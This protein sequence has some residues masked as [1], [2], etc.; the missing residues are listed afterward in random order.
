M[1]ISNI[2]FNTMLRIA[3]STFNTVR[4]FVCANVFFYFLSDS[5]FFSIQRMRFIN[6]NEFSSAMSHIY[7]SSFSCILCYRQFFCAHLNRS[8]EK[9]CY[10]DSKNHSYT[11]FHDNMKIN[12]FG[13]LNPIIFFSLFNFQQSN[14][15]LFKFI[16][17]F[18]KRWTNEN[19]KNAERRKFTLIAFFFA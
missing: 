19:G 3:L 5:I 15:H 10:N 11:F 16:G 1:H 6:A 17:I 9:K 12:R 8:N 18:S 7:L 14:R 2:L 4:L 13:F